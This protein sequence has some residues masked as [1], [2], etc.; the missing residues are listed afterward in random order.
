MQRGWR[1]D[2]DKLTFIICLPPIS[3]TSPLSEHS[4][5]VLAGHDDNGPAMLGDI[6]LFL[7]EEHGTSEEFSPDRGHAGKK[8]VVGELELMIAR[9][10]HQGKGYGRASVLLFLWYVVIR[11]EELVASYCAG[12]GVEGVLTHLRVKIHQ[13]NRRSIGLFESL[14]FKKSDE[15]PNYFG[16]Y[17]LILEDLDVVRMYGLMKTYGLGECRNLNYIRE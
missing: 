12:A 17:D 9:R 3:P 8:K 1:T 10:E 14:L 6:N 2:A 16:E 11:R 5:Q 13:D 15:T 4:E 7:S